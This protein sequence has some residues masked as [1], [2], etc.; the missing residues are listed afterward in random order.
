MSTW[1]DVIGLLGVS[2]ERFNRTYQIQ[3]LTPKT[4]EMINEMANSLP[5][6]C[7]DH[8]YNLL[9]RSLDT[10]DTIDNVPGTIPTQHFEAIMSVMDTYIPPSDRA[11]RKLIEIFNR[12]SQSCGQVW[13]SN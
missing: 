8:L 7:Q 5:V 11:D 3:E 6:N 2:N 1:N 13:L 10:I 4:I 12:Y 9:I